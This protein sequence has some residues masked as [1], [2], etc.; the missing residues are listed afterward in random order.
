MFTITVQ[1]GDLAAATADTLIVNLFQGVV[2]PGG[3][4]GA[5]DQALGGA[6]SELIAAGDL[7]GRVGEIRVLYPRGALTARR[8]IVVGL[9]KREGFDLLA[10]RNA[11]AHAIRAA[12]AHGAQAVASIV[13][14]AGVGGLDPAAA[15][16]AVV[17]GSLLALHRNPFPRPS[18]EER[19][20]P[21]LTLVE[22]DAARIPQ[23]EQAVAT[24]RAVCDGVMLARDLV[25]APANQCTPDDLAAVAQE[26]AAR[27][28]LKLTVGGRKWARERQMGAFLAVAQGAGLKPRFI[29]LEH[30]AERTDLPT[31]VLVGKG[32]VF[33]SGGIS[34]K[35][36]QGMERMKNDMG[37]AAAVLGALQAAAALQLPLRL[38]GIAPCTENKPDAD[39][40]RPSDVIVASNGKTIEIISTDA[41]GRLVLA[42]ALVYAGQYKPDL[43]IDLATL[44]GMA[45]R[46]M[47][48]GI[49]AALFCNHDHYRD[50]LLVAGAATHERLWP[51]PLWPDYRKA[52]NS[53][54]ADLKNSGGLTGGLGTSAAFLQEF[55]AY[56]WAHL[57]IAGVALT[58]NGVSQAYE[59]HGATGFGVR[60]LIEFLRNWQTAP[61]N[62]EREA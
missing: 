1:R 16:Q 48:D 7:T 15:A 32:I 21:T 54:V 18:A 37:G 49:A 33:D 35:P 14:G 29:V 27:H 22:I 52:I 34:I 6:I 38:I 57:D 17:E 10:V 12:H 11:A 53:P 23:L 30:N 43:V 58:T 47:G 42:D 31:I 2:K 9:G 50:R 8:V 51:F 59:K 45:A 40:Y 61:A 60:L 20:L 26:I 56:P 24:A 28:N 25:F 19:P 3:A 36:G 46:A 41:E 4:T 62:G 39:A 5:L 55:T 13:H 44:T